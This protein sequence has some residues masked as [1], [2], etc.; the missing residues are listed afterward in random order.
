MKIENDDLWNKIKEGELKGLSIEGYFVDKLEKMGKQYTDEEIRKAYKELQAEGK[1]QLAKTIPAARTK[2]TKTLKKYNNYV[3][4]EANKIGHELDSYSGE[5][6]NLEAV[7][8]KFIKSAKDLG[9]QDVVQ[10]LE[11]DLNL[12]KALRKNAQKK[13]SLVDKL[14]Q[15]RI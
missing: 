9:L 4:K 13:G 15:D 11:R 8:V 1:I 2:L 7:F 14:L 6:F 12:C 5:F 3:T 10:K